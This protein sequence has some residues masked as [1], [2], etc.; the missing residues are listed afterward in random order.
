MGYT[1]DRVGAHRARSCVAASNE[2]WVT[3]VLYVLRSNVFIKDDDR[4]SPQ[5][6]EHTSENHSP[7][8]L[9]GRLLLEKKKKLKEM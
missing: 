4:A 2:T 5:S 7:D 9:L 8:P 3:D 6:E 1:R